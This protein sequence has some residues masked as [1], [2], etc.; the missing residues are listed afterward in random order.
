MADITAE[1]DLDSVIDRLLEGELASPKERKD[2]FLFSSWF[3]ETSF[4]SFFWAVWMILSHSLLFFLFLGGMGAWYFM[5]I[6]FDGSVLLHLMMWKT[7][8]AGRVFFSLVQSPLPRNLF[9]MESLK[10][11]MSLPHHVLF[12]C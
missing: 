12:L 3:F 5:T 9:H 8:H 7:M 11:S 4:S 10:P 1:I 2:L 6:C